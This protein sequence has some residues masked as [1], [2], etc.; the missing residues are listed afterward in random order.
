[1]ATEPTTTLTKAQFEAMKPD[2]NLVLTKVAEQSAFYAASQQIALSGNGT[3]VHTFDSGL[4]TYV[5][6]SGVKPVVESVG[7]TKTVGA[8]KFAK[9]V[10]LTNELVQDSP[11]IANAIYGTIPDSL[12]GALDTIISGAAPA[13]SSSFDTFASLTTSINV[14]TPEALHDVF[15]TVESKN[16]RV[17]SMVISSALYH[18]LRGARTALGFPIFNMIGDN[19]RGEIE[20]VPY[21]V[22][23]STRVEGF[24]GPF[25]S[26]AV[27]GIV[28]D[29]N[30]VRVS[31]EASVNDGEKT[32]NLWQEN[33]VGILAEARFG[34]RVADLDEFVK[35][36][37]DTTA[38][39][40]TPEG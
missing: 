19:K 21:F 33:K 36:T 25:A 4:G 11:T 35:V 6:E 29:P 17:D 27:W 28:E 10:V 30:L 18:R 15:A 5:T 23:R 24:V 14:T 26:R 38:P 2:S 39:E 9:I 13:P 3:L 22:Y 12:Q 40:E 8:H 16:V 1:M 31:T 7:S 34:F 37:F 32:I 20:G